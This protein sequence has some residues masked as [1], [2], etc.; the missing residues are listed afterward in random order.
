MSNQPKDRT[1]GLGRLADRKT[2]GHFLLHPAT[3]AAT[4]VLGI[5]L[6]AV[7]LTQA[8]TAR[9]VR[10]MSSDLP[11]DV[12]QAV[13]SSEAE[14]ETTAVAEDA[15]AL[16]TEA[17]DQ[18]AVADA[19]VEPAHET[20]AVAFYADWGDAGY[21][22][23]ERNID[24]IDV[25]MPMW[26]HIG[27]D[28][29][30]TLGSPKGKE[31]VMR[32]IR[33]KNPDM[34]VMPIVNNYDKRAETWNPK[35]VAK[36]MGKRDKRELIAKRIVAEMKDEGFDGINIDLEG[37]KEKDRDVIVAFMKEL[38]PRANK[39]GLEVSQDVIVGSAA[40]DHRKL[41]KYNDYMI[42]M[43]YDQ[44]WKTSGP[45][46]IS[47]QRWYERT[48][49]RF[50]QQVPPKKVLI[51]LGT[52]A[53][54]WVPGKRA[55]SLTF[56]EATALAR[57]KDKGIRLDKDGMNSHFTY[58]KGD[59]KHH[60][61]MLDAASAYNQMKAASEHEPA[62]FALWRLGAEDPALWRIMPHRDSLDAAEA[63]SLAGSQRTVDYDPDGGLIVGQ[64]ILP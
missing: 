61:W 43:M 48:L 25:L 32:L 27:S 31:R 22:S 50:F 35:Q 44:H 9:A 38:Y 55:K 26:Y 40:Y 36:L 11:P 10:D 19:P 18:A 60:V 58:K 63:A 29:K 37:F 33:E 47:S 15:P 12:Q 3:I 16:V 1:G 4:V 34:K 2:L 62:G 56:A 59:K 5:V 41:S 6:I 14:S 54:D 64:R 7:P 17:D 42:P 8:A 13:I 46:P 53:Y 52:Y 49:R 23:L 57:K 28:G 30:L 51:G 24:K 45:G 39:A 21:R 20:L